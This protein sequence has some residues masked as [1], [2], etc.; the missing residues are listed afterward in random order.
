MP[1][2]SDSAFSDDTF[3]H[4]SAL[5]TRGEPLAATLDLI[6]R[7]TCDLLEVQRAALFL[8]EEPGPN[9]QLIA[10][11]R[12]L[13]EAPVLRPPGIGV[14]GWVMRRGRP[15]VVVNP[16][17]D[18]RFTPLPD[19]D[20]TLPPEAI[21][22]VAA[23]PV[24]SRS[25]LVG[26][27]SVADAPHTHQETPSGHPLSNASITD[28]LP[29]LAVL[30]DLVGLALENSDILH[31]QD[32]RTQLIRLLHTI[33]AIPLSEST[34]DLAHT[35]TDQI[36]TI[37]PADLASILLHSP[38]TDELIAFGGSET[39]LGLLQRERGLDHIPL[40][41][42]GP[43]L[44]VFQHGT[45]LRL[46]SA[47]ELAALPLLQVI[48]IQSMLI[49]PLRNEQVSIGLLML[50]A[51]RA[52]AFSDDD[53]SFLTFISVRLGY[54]L[55]HD[56]LSDEL[57]A[58]EQARIRQEER[59]NFLSI[60]AHDLKNA[61]TA[62]AGSSHLA[63]RKAARGDVT[64]SQKAL[65]VVVTKAAQALQLV[66]DML[67]IN[68]VDAGQFRLFMAP[69]EL[70]TLLQEE[71]EGAQGLSTQHSVVLET[72]LEAVEVAADAHRLRQ[73]L[74]NLLTNA[75]RYAPEGCR[76]TVGLSIR[77]AQA[78][79]AA[80]QQAAEQIPE[81]LITVSDQGMGI[82]PHDVP[83]I[84]ERFY[85]GRGEYVASGSGLGLYI[86][87]E[88]ITQH[89]GRIWAESNPGAGACFSMTLP[90]R[91]SSPASQ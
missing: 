68:R 3:A 54:A 65:P 12:G 9:L 78:V 67:D 45:P 89:G 69:V 88:I 74:T 24:R 8:I 82:A 21:S 60:I 14:E 46:S 30:A 20:D 48:G 76:I 91:R 4:I 29:F 50:A 28:L 73:V 81:V 23:V 53:M 80:G 19:W 5:I 10:A 41:T 63:L 18:P 34:E 52:S 44:Q 58:A 16:A 86:A 84:F 90:V 70:V 64:Y 40:A 26:V 72:T 35:I 75:I 36:S 15:I 39:P 62:I 43:L 22:V 47:D 71:V 11:S 32:R 37:M 6:M 66:N 79:A 7:R 59:D 57:A 55:H 38:A 83:H 25:R 1:R 27:L 33:A 2:A 51:T 56:T 85:R 87:A 61:L 13:P 17:A 49:V 77:A 42:S 31:H